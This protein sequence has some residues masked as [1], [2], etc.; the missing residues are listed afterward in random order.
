[1]TIE[2]AWDNIDSATQRLKAEQIEITVLNK[3]AGEH[4]RAAS[5]ELLKK[6]DNRSLA[7]FCEKIKVSAA[8]VASFASARSDKIGAR[9]SDRR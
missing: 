3:K 7:E 2:K 4:F 5:V 8:L 6:G 9:L 1:M